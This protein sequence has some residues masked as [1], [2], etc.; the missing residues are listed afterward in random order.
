MFKFS[1]YKSSQ[2]TWVYY[3]LQAIRE[4][5]RPRHQSP[6]FSNNAFGK[7]QLISIIV[8]TYQPARGD[9]LPINSIR[10]SELLSSLKSYNKK[11]TIVRD[12]VE[13]RA[14]QY[15]KLVDIA[16]LVKSTLRSVHFT[17]SHCRKYSRY[18][19]LIFVRIQQKC[20]QKYEFLWGKR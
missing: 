4:Q 1:S 12:P 18:W 10:K 8:A 2:Q 7:I 11:C 14:R 9:V 20:Q 15:L 3:A 16:L 5:P 19:I 17:T 6:T 13:N